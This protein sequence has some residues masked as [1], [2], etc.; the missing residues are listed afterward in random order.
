MFQKVKF[1]LQVNK[2]A[3]VIE[4]E[5]KMGNFKPGIMILKGLKALALGALAVV[6]PPL[7]AY[8]SDPA[9]VGA[10]LSAAGVPAAVTAVVVPLIIGGI[11]MLN[12]YKK[13]KDK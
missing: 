5:M 4:K 13:N 12:N 2:A 11:A 10:A 3:G 7:V 8:V 6:I 9:V 1:L